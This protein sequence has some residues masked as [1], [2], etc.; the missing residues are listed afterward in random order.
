MK[1]GDKVIVRGNG[2]GVTF[3]TL[4]SRSGSEVKLADCRKIWYWEGAASLYQ[5]AAEGVKRPEKCKFTVFLEE[6][7]IIDAIEVLPCSDMA[8]ISIENVRIW[9]I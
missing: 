7:E 1:T 8:V 5:L 6:A 3:G 2:S 4:V 9:K